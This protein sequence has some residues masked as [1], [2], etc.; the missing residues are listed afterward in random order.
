MLTEEPNAKLYSFDGAVVDRASAGGEEGGQQ[1][2]GLQ[3][4][5]LNRGAAE[6]VAAGG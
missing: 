3:L 6:Q 4:C 2:R 5:A 1:V